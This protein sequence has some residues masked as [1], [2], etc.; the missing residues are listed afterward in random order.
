[1]TPFGPSK[2]YARRID[3]DRRGEFG[4]DG[5]VGEHFV[6]DVLTG[7]DLGDELII[8]D[9]C[10]SILPRRDEREQHFPYPAGLNRVG[11]PFD[12][13][14]ILLVAVETR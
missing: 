6:V 1:L 11:L 7:I 8:L 13:V 3:G 4:P 10:G 12:V 5:F 9:I 2:R 14:E